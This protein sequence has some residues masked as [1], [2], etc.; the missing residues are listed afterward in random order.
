MIAADGLLPVLLERLSRDHARIAG[1]I[2]RLADLVD[3]LDDNPDWSEISA[4]IDFLDYYADKVHHPLEDKVF[5]YLV[6][7]GLTPTERHLVLKNLGQH[8]EISGMTEDLARLSAQ[9]VDGAVM[10]M[11]EFVDALQAYIVLQNR[12]MRFEEQQLFPLLDQSLENAD[13]NTLMK[14]VNLPEHDEIVETA[15]YTTTHTTTDIK[16]AIAKEES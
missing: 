11:P 4:H 15:V 5:D 10:D 3:D 12:H 7:K 9:A 6:N 1:V 13:W 8:A 16:N 14:V 2:K